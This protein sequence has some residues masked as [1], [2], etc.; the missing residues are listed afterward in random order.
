MSQVQPL[1]TSQG[2]TPS[3]I[4][5]ALV[6][7]KIVQKPRRFRAA[8]GSVYLTLLRLAA[9]DEFTAPGTIELRSRAPLGEVGDV[10]RG[11]VRITGYGRSFPSKPD[12]ETGEV[13]QVRTADNRLEVVE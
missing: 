12:P 9:P 4:L 5:T 8:D 3:A 11:K 13:S 7:G 10:W 2:A 1:P 6:A